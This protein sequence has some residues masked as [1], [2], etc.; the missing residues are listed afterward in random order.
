MS[1]DASIALKWA[2]GD[3]VFRLPIGQLRELQE[4]TGIGPNELLSRLA[5]GTWRIDD[6]RETIRLGL[7]GGGKPPISALALCER[8]VDARPWLENAP[9]ARSILLAALVGVPDDPAGK[10]EAVEE[11]N[12]MTDELASPPST[13]PESS[14]A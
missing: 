13:E 2:D 14:S 10:A 1:G 3:H 11:N 6:I 9:Y 12:P 8:Y 4:K 5:S 7:I